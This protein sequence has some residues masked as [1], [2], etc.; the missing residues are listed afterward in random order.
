MQTQVS[1]DLPFY[2]CSHSSST[3]VTLTKTDRKIDRETT[4]NT[5]DKV[6]PAYVRAY[7]CLCQTALQK[8]QFH[9]V[10]RWQLPAFGRTAVPAPSSSG[11]CH[12][13]LLDTKQ[14]V[15]MVLRNVG[16]CNPKDNASRPKRFESPPPFRHYKSSA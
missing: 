2:V 13:G 14:K 4:T 16:N 11:S 3:F 7:E 6:L 1:R 12:L 9:E 5:N 10:L 15:A 8:V